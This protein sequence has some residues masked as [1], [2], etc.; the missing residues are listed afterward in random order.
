MKQQF[1]QAIHSKNKVKMT[2]YSKEDG[3]ELT[4]VVAPMDYGP[5]NTAHD[6]SDRYH[7]W[8]YDSD[9]KPHPLSLHPDQVVALEVLPDTFDPAEFV[10]WAPKWTIDREWGP[11]S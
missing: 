9:T 5:S 8:D 10:T 4:R 2:F 3:Q 7:S 11:H 6:W 1:I